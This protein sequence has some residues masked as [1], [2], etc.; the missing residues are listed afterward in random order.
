MASESKESHAGVQNKVNKRE[1]CTI[2]KDAFF[3]GHF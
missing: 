3:G 1:L 2:H